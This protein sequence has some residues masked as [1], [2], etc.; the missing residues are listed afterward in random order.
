MIAFLPKLAL[1]VGATATTID[2]AWALPLNTALLIIM[3]IL[4]AATHGR[5]KAT[6]QDVGHA[7]SAAADAAQAAA[8][9]ARISRELGGVA[10]EVHP[11]SNP[12]TP[13]PPAA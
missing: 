6:Q 4:N 2:P 7:A 12:P 10:R 1:V 3:A 13:T 11:P 8:D 9:A 5:V